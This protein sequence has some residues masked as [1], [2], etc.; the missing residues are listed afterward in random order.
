MSH[1]LIRI[2]GMKKLLGLDSISELVDGKL[3][4]TE[5]DFLVDGIKIFAGIGDIPAFKVRLSSNLQSKTA[6][7][8]VLGDS[9]NRWET[10]YFHHGKC[11]KVKARISQKEGLEITQALFKTTRTGF[12]NQKIYPLGFAVKRS[13]CKL[14]PF[15]VRHSDGFS[16]NAFYS[17]RDS[18]HFLIH[19]FFSD[20]GTCSSKLVESKPSKNLLRVITKLAVVNPKI[21]DMNG[22]ELKPDSLPVLS[23]KLQCDSNKPFFEFESLG[24]VCQALPL[25]NSKWQMSLTNHIPCHSKNIPSTK[26][27][28]SIDYNKPVFMVVQ[29]SSNTDTI[30]KLGSVF[31][32][33]DR[34]ARIG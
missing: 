3:S 23:N 22:T 34:F 28:Q 27:C 19:G 18:N 29:S 11:W 24:K 7:G 13:Y 4:Q 9:K 32:F 31:S 20:D 17:V 33:T 2:T 10:V 5:H 16:V 8:N 30:E 25:P 6:K 1:A 15:L 14:G 26:L 12:A 21:F